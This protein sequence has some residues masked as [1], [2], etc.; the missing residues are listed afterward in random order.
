MVPLHAGSNWGQPK[1]GASPCR[2]RQGRP[3]GGAQGSWAKCTP[4][5]GSRPAEHPCRGQPRPS[6]GCCGRWLCRRRPLVRCAASA[7]SRCTNIWRQ[8]HQVAVREA[9]PWQCAALMT[10]TCTASRRGSHLLPSDGALGIVAAAVLCFST[11]CIA[12]H[13]TCTA[14]VSVRNELAQHWAMTRPLQQS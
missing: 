14:T 4:A 6:K 10:S 13:S 2:R 11:C 8:S 7:S 12:R 5:Q 1:S 3:R 9:A